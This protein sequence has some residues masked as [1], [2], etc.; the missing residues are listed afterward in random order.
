MQ[1]DKKQ[2]INDSINKLQV[3]LNKLL[4]TAEEVKVMQIELTE[5]RPIIDAARIDV[6]KMVVVIEA[7]R[8]SIYTVLNNKTLI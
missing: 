5:I 6:Q 8:V 4:T 3:G 1:R 7:D 2:E